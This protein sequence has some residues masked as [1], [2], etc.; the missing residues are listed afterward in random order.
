MNITSVA[1]GTVFDTSTQ[2]NL[3]VTGSRTVNI[4]GAATSGITRTINPASASVNNSISQ[5]FDFNLTA[6]AAG[7]TITFGASRYVRNLNFTGTSSTITQGG[8]TIA[9]NLN[10]G[11]TATFTAGSSTW[12]F[13]PIG[14]G[15]V[16][17]TTN[18]KTIDWPILLSGVGTLVLQDSLTMGT[19]RAFSINIGILNLNGYTLT[20]G[21]MSVG[22]Q[23]TAPNGTNNVIGNSLSQIILAGT[24]TVWSWTASTQNF[25]SVPAITLTDTSTTARTMA[26]SNA[27]YQKITIGGSTGT[28]TTT[29]TGSGCYVGEWAS[30]K[31]VAHTIVFPSG[32]QQYFDK[33]SITGTA[34]NVVTLAPSTAASLFYFVP[35]SRVTGVNYLSI[36]YCGVSPYVIQGGASVLGAEFYAGANSTN[37]GGNTRFIY[38]TAAPVATTRYWVGGSGTWDTTTTTNWSTSSG[39][40]G[41][42]SVPTSVDN[43]VFDSASSSGS[44]SVT[45]GATSIETM[46][47]D[48]TIS[49]P[50]SGTLTFGGGT[51]TLAIFGSL[52]IA[53][54]GVTLT[55]LNTYAFAS[56][57]TGKTIT[58]NGLTLPYYVNFSGIGGEWTLG[59]ALSTSGPYGIYVNAGS[60]ITANYNIS[61]SQLYSASYF[62]RSINLGS[63]TVTFSGLGGNI[64]SVYSDSNLT[65]NAGTSSIILNT[66]A[67]PQTI[68]DAALPTPLGLTLYNFTYNLSAV[69]SSLVVNGNFVL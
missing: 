45:L 59:S 26:L 54:T 47:N 35:T 2:A 5:Y 27:N 22:S 9:G 58:T 48:L 20:T 38:F 14:S 21:T 28:S 67:N 33:W 69:P 7:S 66:A 43:V 49:G 61:T 34:G 12:T 51:P 36:S 29:I 3:T 65:W 24:G 32:V 53:G 39:G 13:Q 15:S 8:I 62:P 64:L 11:S 50:A 46:V 30:T 55:G 57:T 41:G 40:T 52:S 56:T 44:Y 18:A 42:A 4:S 16:T 19:T 17:V 6:G 10:L 31:T 63:S 23:G 25:T 1:T 37:G 60:L 68:I